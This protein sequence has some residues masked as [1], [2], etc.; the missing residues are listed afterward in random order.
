[1][2]T[3]L[4]NLKIYKMAEEL[5]LKVFNLTKLFPR[6]EKFRSV[7]Q[8]R[9]SS[10]SVTNNIAESYNKR[11]LKEKIRI[12]HDIAKS[13]AEETKRNLA[14]CIKKEFHSDDRIVEDYTELIKAISGYVRFLKNTDQ[15]KK[16]YR[17]ISL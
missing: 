9:R 5:E 4:D 16:I 10:S 15:S 17:L 7:D 2:A 8:L 14:I 1:M 13:E 6:D 11:S 12:L 3:G